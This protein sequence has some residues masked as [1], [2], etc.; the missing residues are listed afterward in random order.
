MGVNYAGNKGQKSGCLQMGIH[1]GAGPHIPEIAAGTPWVCKQELLREDATGPISQSAA[2]PTRSPG[3]CLLMERGPLPRRQGKPEKQFWCG[4]GWGRSMGTC[5]ASERPAYV[6]GLPFPH[7]QGCL[8]EGESLRPEEVLVGCPHQTKAP[9]NTNPGA[10][11]AGG[12]WKSWLR[13]TVAGR[14]ASGRDTT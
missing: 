2:P 12:P 6:R 8:S 14:R 7:P 4:A 11:Q 10:P 9:Q 5:P 13:S 3:H 1:L